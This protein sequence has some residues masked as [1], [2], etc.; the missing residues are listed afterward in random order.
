MFACPHCLTST[1]S[2][3]RKAGASRTFPV[4]CSNCHSLSFVSG[5]AHA[6]TGL[7][8]EVLL[9]GTVIAA[10]VAKSWLILFF[11]PAGLLLWSMIVGVT[12]SLRPIEGPAVHRARRNAAIQVGALLFVALVAGVLSHG[13][14]P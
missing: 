7:V 8:A 5:W 3:W 9:W 12:F 14:S 2:P 4:R 6:A 13:A 11:L 10:L 1:I